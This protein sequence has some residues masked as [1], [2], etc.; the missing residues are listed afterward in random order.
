MTLY[1]ANPNS[2]GAREAM[3]DHRLG[4]IRTPVQGNA[5]PEG[6]IW[7]ADNGCFGKGYPGDEGWIEWLSSLDPEGCRFAT[8]PDVVGDAAATLERS[9]PF[10]EVIRSLGFPAA[11]VAQDGLEDLAVPWDRIDALFI[12]GTTDWKMGPE[13]ALLVK[14][15]RRRGKYVHFGRVNSFKRYKYAHE[16]G[17]HSV[18]GTYLVFGPKVNLPRLLG[19]VDKIRACCPGPTHW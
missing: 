15:A 1:F 11:L 18:D 9:A 8:A 12:G 10:Y 6:A 19:W 7:C 3:R 2:D 14:E 16:I 4:F 17:C 13:A 5:R